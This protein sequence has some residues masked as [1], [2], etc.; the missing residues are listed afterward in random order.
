[1]A[2][3]PSSDKRLI[4]HGQQVQ[5]RLR[6][7]REA[8]QRSRQRKKAYMAALEAEVRAW[9]VAPESIAV[10]IMQTIHFGCRLACGHVLR[11]G[12]ALA[13]CHES[14]HQVALCMLCVMDNA[15]AQPAHS[16][17]DEAPDGKRVPT[18]QHSGAMQLY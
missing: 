18:P 2:F 1:M 3:T 7:N 15:T 8:A 14:M 6:Q 11:C 16:M 17:S 13:M 9:V 4:C 5:R 12:W 10:P